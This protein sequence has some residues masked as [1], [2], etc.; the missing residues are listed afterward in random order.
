MIARDSLQQIRKAQ[1][2]RQVFGAVILQNV[3]PNNG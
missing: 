2:F 1:N 3:E